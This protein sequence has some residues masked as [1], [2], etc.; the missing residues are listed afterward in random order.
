MNE[1]AIQDAY[2][3][4]KGAGYNKS[5]EE[6]KLLMSTNSEALNDSYIL[7]KDAGYNNSIEDFKVLVGASVKKKGSMESFLVDGSLE[8]Q[9]SDAEVKNLE[10]FLTEQ[11]EETP[12]QEVQPKYYEEVEAPSE[13]QIQDAA[14]ADEEAAK[15]ARR[16]TTDFIDN[17]ADGTAEEIYTYDANGNAIRQEEDRD[18]DGISDEIT[19]FTYDANG[20]KTREEIDN[21][22]DGTVDETYIYDANGNRINFD[23]A[24]KDPE[25]IFQKNLEN[26]TPELVE[27]SEGNVV[28]F[29]NEIFKQEGFKF[30]EAAPLLDQ[31]LVYPP[32]GGAPKLFELDAPTE[33]ERDFSLRYSRRNEKILSKNI[34]KELKKFITDNRKEVVPE[35]K[36]FM[37]D[38]RRKNAIEGF[39]DRE[40][41]YKNNTKE[42]KELNA[43]IEKDAEVFRDLSKEDIN[44]DPETRERYESYIDNI[45]TAEIQRE[46][47]IEETKILAEKGVEL[48]VIAANSA[49]AQALRGDW[50]GGLYNSFLGGVGDMGAGLA[51]SGIDIATNFQKNAG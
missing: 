35:G 45:K 16:D 33:N 27:G 9:E 25:V 37:T 26:I 1:E 31:M 24:N 15:Y 12:T 4:F 13:A 21:D 18:R 51:G 23:E 41:R 42:Y 46:A 44:A 50:L 6:F 30:E 3:L 19:T 36:M 34:A 32:G 5:I 38:A 11:L 8:P 22:G 14:Q 20:D 39:Q 10:S 40:A 48:D 29:L 49:E 47:L 43:S 28:P 2:I 17:D 7:F